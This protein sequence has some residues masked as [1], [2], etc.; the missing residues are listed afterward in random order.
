MRRFPL[1]ADCA[2]E[3][4]DP[5]D[6]RFHA[7]PVACPACGPTLAWGDL[8]GEQALKAAVRAVAT[9]GSSRS[10]DSAATSWC[11]TRPTP[12]RWQSCGGESAG[13]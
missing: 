3:Y 8:R 1:C 10:R 4:T 6:R 13:R 2:A 9:G 7:E 11:A 12:T 5:R